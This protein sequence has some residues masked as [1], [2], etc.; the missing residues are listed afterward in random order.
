VESIYRDARWYELQA[1]KEDG[2]P[3][4]YSFQDEQGSMVY[5]FIK[6]EAGIVN[7]QKYYDLVTT[8]GMGGP[9]VEATENELKSFIQ[10]TQ[11]YFQEYCK[12]EHI[13]A[14]YVKFDP[15]IKNADQF[16]S[17]YIVEHHGNTYGNDLTHDFYQSEYHT[18]ARAR[19]KKAVDSGVEVRFDHCGETISKFLELYQYTKNKYHVSQFYDID[20]SFVE[21]YFDKLEGKVCIANAIWN[22]QTISSVLVVFGKDIAHYHFLGNDPKYRELQA[23]TLLTY[24]C[25]K[26]ARS[27][28]KKIFDL[29]GSVLGSGVEDFKKKFVREQNKYP[30]YIGKCIRNEEIYQI[31]VN[32]KKERRPGFFPEYRG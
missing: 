16:Q 14:E 5:E 17:Y 1:L 7:N 29:G 24:E 12:Q 2:T 20:Q 10:K 3:E 19:I 23:N 11:I 4:C 22:K 26:L 31:L 25:A 18:N 27:L 6:R 32:E 8:R 15:W 28:G 21:A 30:Y 9:I 13:I